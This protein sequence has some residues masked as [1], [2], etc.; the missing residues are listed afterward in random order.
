MILNRIIRWTAKGLELEADPRQCER[1]VEECGLVGANTTATPGTK[2]GT[3]QI[4]ADKD[5][6]AKLCTPFRG[7]A[8]RANY[9]CADRI[10]CQFAAKEICRLMSKPTELAWTALKRLARF[11][12]GLPRLVYSFDWQTADHVEVYSDT[13]WSGCART[14][15]STAG[16]VI[17]IGTHVIKTWS[18]TLPSVS[19]SSG[20]A[21]FY[22]VVKAAGMGLGYGSLLAD[23]NVQLPVRVWTDSSAAMGVC[24]RQGLGRLR[25]IDT[26]TPCGCSRR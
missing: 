7:A 25:H 22:G 14:R 4:L 3:E 11:L 8:A 26:H 18:S 10:D 13:D 23:L 16:G 2:P 9:L 17:M 19:L 20:E 15:K 24:T 5:L 6:E 1:L 21:E 12:A